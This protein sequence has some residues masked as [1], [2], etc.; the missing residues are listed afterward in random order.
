M[1]FSYLVYDLLVLPLS[2]LP[3][4]VL[5]GLS[6]H[7]LFPLV[8]WLVGYRRKV[9]RKNLANAFPEK[10]EAERKRLEKAFYRHFCDL[11]VESIKFFSI[12]QEEAFRRMECVNPELPAK[13][14]QE[15]KHVIL[16][17]GHYNNWE[18]Y[19]IAAAGHL[20]HRPVVIYHPLRNKVFDKALKRTRSRFGTR[21]VTFREIPK[22]LE[23]NEPSGVVFV[24]DQSPRSGKN[25]HWMTFLNQWTGVMRGTE[26]MAREYGLPVIYGVLRRKKKRGHFKLTYHEVCSNGRD[27]AEGEITEK[28]TRLLEEHIRER[29][30][31]WLWT[32]RRWK[33]KGQVGK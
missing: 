27:T 26:K 31:F 22:I 5:Y 12:S 11:I 1:V 19:G 13:Y 20:E 32:H 33:K 4:K 3:F 21:L 7:V 23:G 2:H 30:E 8:Y 9:V 10:S 16:V 15:G 18:L 25:A 29:P 28:H 24:G 6:D 14:Y 17:G